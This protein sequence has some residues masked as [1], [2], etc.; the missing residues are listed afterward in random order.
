MLAPGKIARQRIRL[1]L[2]EGVRPEIF[3]LKRAEPTAIMWLLPGK[4]AHDHVLELTFQFPDAAAP[5]DLGLSDDVRRLSVSFI[6]LRVFAEEP[7]LALNG[8]S[9]H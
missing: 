5:A 1:I 7:T 2:P 3:E 4:L 8:S 9:A 6:E